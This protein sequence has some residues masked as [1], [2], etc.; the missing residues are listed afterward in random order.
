[1]KQKTSRRLTHLA[2]HVALVLVI[3]WVIFP[4]F[5]MV[6]SSFMPESDQRTTIFPAILPSRLDFSGWNYLFFNLGAFADFRNSLGISTIATAIVIGV[7]ILSGYSLARFQFKG[8][9]IAYNLLLLT[10]FVPTVANLLTLFVVLHSIGLVD[11]WA[12]LI[13]L[14]ASSGS[15][16]ATLLFSG[17]FTGL[18]TGLEDAAMIDGTTR[19]GAFLRVILPLM[20]PG[21]I[22]VGLFTWIS[23]WGDIQIAT[24][25]TLTDASR[26]L[27]VALVQLLTPYGTLNFSAMFAIGTVLAVPPLILFLIFQRYFNPTLSG[28]G[29]KG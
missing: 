10:Q 16:L 19:L 5:W 9:A 27:P 17:F 28:G 13:I 12:A 23:F 8:K 3:F 15:V 29:W 20:K 18:P 1:M 7:T 2:T 6:S 11:T 22:T 21:L 14:Y 24:I 4:V 26:T 25:F